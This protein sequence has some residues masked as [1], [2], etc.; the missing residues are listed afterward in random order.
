LG[1]AYREFLNRAEAQGMV[2]GYAFIALPQVVGD[3][4]GAGI[5]TLVLDPAYT[6]FTFEDSTMKIDGAAERVVSVKRSDY[7]RVEISSLTSS[8]T[9]LQ[10]T[11]Y[12]LEMHGSGTTN[13]SK[14]HWDFMNLFESRLKLPTQ[15]TY[16]AVGSST[17]RA[18]F[19]ANVNDFGCSEVPMSASEVGQMEAGAVVL[20]FPLVLGAV[21][22]FHSVPGSLSL[23]GPVLAKV[24]ARTITTWDDAEILALNPDL[25][26]PAGQAI[27]VVHRT[28]GSSSTYLTTQYLDQFTEWTLGYG[29]TVSWDAATVAVEGSGGMSDYIVANAWS[30]GYMDTGHG[31]DLGLSELAIANA[32]GVFLTSLEADIGAAASNVVLPASDGDWSTVN[33][34]NLPGNTT[35]PLCAFSYMLVRQDL[36]AIGDRGTLVKAYL[37]FIN[38]AEAQG[39]VGGYSFIALPQ[40][41]VDLNVAGIAT[42]VLDPAYTQFTFEDSTMSI[43]GAAE[44]VVSVKRSDYERV[45]ISSL[46]D[47]VTILAADASNFTTDVQAITDALVA[48]EIMVG[49]GTTLTGNDGNGDSDSSPSAVAYASLVLALISLILSGGA[50]YN[51][52]GASAAPK[53]A[54]VAQNV[55]YEGVKQENSVSRSNADSQSGTV[56]SA[57]EMQGVNTDN[58]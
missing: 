1:K 54:P 49:T 35:W 39:M 25:V 8:I 23:T 56:N 20:H 7:E 21:G 28:F 24:F 10:T 33:L 27:T 16:R 19:I 9:A 32:A 51:S 14:V 47:A 31:H 13:P 30:I 52:V 57:V 40:V 11:T 4:N 43:T 42:L 53:D 48:A 18:E 58:K 55:T 26:V 29:S 22:I 46:T 17:G 50:L 38:S 37:E 36:T 41:V 12:V 44:R 3:L 34:I 6:Q 2:G 15:I 5:A 45:E